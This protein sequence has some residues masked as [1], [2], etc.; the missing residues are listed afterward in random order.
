MTFL[1]NLEVR[2]LYSEPRWFFFYIL[3][4]KQV[5]SILKGTKNLQF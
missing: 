2:I 4:L 5:I 1:S 3:I